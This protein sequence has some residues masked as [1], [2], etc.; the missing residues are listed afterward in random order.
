MPKRGLTHVHI[1]LIMQ[2][3]A[4]PRTPEMINRV[5]SAEIPDKNVNPKLYDIITS[6]NI[7]GP[8]GRSVN[9]NRPCMEGEGIQ[10]HCS[11][12]FPKSFTDTTIVREDA[13]PQYRRRSPDQGGQTHKIRLHGQD[14][15]VDNS[16]VV[17]FNPFLSLEYE[18]HINIEIVQ[19]LY[20]VK[21]LY[22][23]ITKGNDRIIIQFDSDGQPTEE[24][25]HDEIEGHIKCKLCVCQ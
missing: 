7:H 2:D 4:K 16:W 1:L 9:H 3:S 23:Y 22:K 13:Y 14:F 18:A 10:K 8:C 12:N 17:P 19:Y 24:V 20:V 15:V 21:Y 25:V 6:N 11:K 5:V